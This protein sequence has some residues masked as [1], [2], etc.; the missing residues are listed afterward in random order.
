MRLARSPARAS[1]PHQGL[2]ISGCQ[3][4]QT[5]AD[6]WFGDRP[7]GAFTYYALKALA[8]LPENATYR[9][10]HA[11][12]REFLPSAAYTQRPNLFGT[13]SQKKWAVLS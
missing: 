1:R 11:A 5:S 3:D 8:K 12:I 9:Q 7:N 2:L 4:T 13:T 10:W 6:A